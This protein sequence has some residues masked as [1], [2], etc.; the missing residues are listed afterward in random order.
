MSAQAP[1]LPLALDPLIAE[2]KRRAWR[3]RGLAVLALIVVA[4]AAGTTVALRSSDGTI[5]FCA[6]P[7]VGWKARAVTLPDQA[8]TLVL[9]NFRFGSMLNFYGLGASTRHWPRGG[10]TIAVEDLSRWRNEASYRGVAPGVLRVRSSQ[11]TGMEGSYF[12]AAN[13]LLEVDGR[14]IETYVE[15]RHV[16]PATVAAANRALVGVH[17]CSS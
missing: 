10:V 16:T 2:A 1:V 9:T 12:P 3:R 15:A 7:P 5:G 6:V 4:A 14:V 11:F 8:P 17:T 13:R